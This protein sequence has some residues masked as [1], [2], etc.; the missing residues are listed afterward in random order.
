MNATDTTNAVPRWQATGLPAIGPLGRIASRLGRFWWLLLVIGAAWIAV[1]FVALRLD[2]STPVVI[3]ITFGIFLL[4]A[5]AGEIMRAVVT[6][7]GWRVWHIIIAVLLLISAVMAFVN[8]SGSFAALVTITGLY[9]VLMGTFDIVSSLFAVGVVPGWWVQLVSGILEI[10]LGFIAAGSFENSAII[11][12][13][14]FSF[15]AVF[16]GVSEIS[17]GFTVRAL[18][19]RV[20]D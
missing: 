11:L 15:T 10:V 19:P 1:G 20:A 8:P 18:A 14:W 9:F 3:A 7:G 5:A 16:R 6:G 17:A 2:R 12:V 13:T 4:V